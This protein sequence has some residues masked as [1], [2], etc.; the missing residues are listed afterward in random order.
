MAVPEFLLGKEIMSHEVEGKKCHFHNWYMQH[1][2]KNTCF[3]VFGFFFSFGL[4]QLGSSSIHPEKLIEKFLRHSKFVLYSKKKKKKNSTSGRN[5]WKNMRNKNCNYL[6]INNTK[7]ILFQNG[8]VTETRL[9]WFLRT[10]LKQET[11]YSPKWLTLPRLPVFSK[12]RI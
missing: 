7:C 4:A 10:K 1:N 2:S 9:H 11:V 5:M 3:L 8:K 6:I 12:S